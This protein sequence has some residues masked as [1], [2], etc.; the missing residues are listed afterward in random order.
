M[1]HFSLFILCLIGTSLTLNAAPRLKK[2]MPRQHAPQMVQQ[3][4]ADD[5]ENLTI[6]P[7]SL[8]DLA[9]IEFSYYPSFSDPEENSYNYTLYIYSD[10][11]DYYPYLAMDIY[12]TEEGKYA[13]TYSAT[14]GNM[15]TEYSGIVVKAE[16]EEGEIEGT[17]VE[18]SDAE[19]TITLNTDGTYTVSGSLTTIDNETY[20]FAITS[21]AMETN[22][23]YP[24]E[25]ITAQEDI[26]LTLTLCE[27]DME[28]VAYGS[29]YIEMYDK[30]NNSLLL[31][32]N[33]DD[34][35][36]EAIPV[37]TYTFAEGTYNAFEVG[38]YY[39]YFGS[40]YGSY[41]LTADDEVFYLN[42]GTVTIGENDYGTTVTVDAYSYFGTH[43]TASYI[44]NSE[45]A[46]PNI[47][48]ANQTAVKVFYDGQILI[49]RGDKLYN[50]QGL[51]VK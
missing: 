31:M 41:L 12:A 17:Y 10:T 26:N 5:E 40:I 19:L 20:E 24:Y 48:N 33:T 50:I 27:W 11:E 22:G 42:S 15:T 21:F 32:Y 7:W 3:A 47:Q 28:Y 16:N 8:E 6:L 49:R 14:K 25:P 29:A 35:A 23:D 46:L 13:G 44:P 9:Y 2:Q 30:Q 34:E 1:K 37:G 43:I 36:L 38:S 18:L 45:T 4:Q 39:S 51:Q